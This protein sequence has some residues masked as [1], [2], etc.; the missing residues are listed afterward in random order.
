MADHQALIALSGQYADQGGRAR[1]EDLRALATGYIAARR[2]SILDAAAIAFTFDAIMSKD[3]FDVSEVTPEMAE[4]WSLAYPNVPI[5]SLAGRST[6]ELAGAI[7]GW[8]GKLFEV[9]VVDRLNSGEWVGDLRLESGQTA[10]IAE[11]A[12]QPGW[13]IQIRDEDGAV[14]DAIQLKA[15][16]SIS[17]VH[18]ALAR[19]P[20]TP[21]L[22]THEVADR[23]GDHPM[24]MDSGISN[25]ALTD[26]VNQHVAD[27]SSDTLSDGVIGA[28]PLS[29]IAITEASKVW[30]GKQT[31]DQALESGGERVA[32][33]VVA[34]AV[35]AAVSSVATPLVGLV[36]GFITRLALTDS[37]QPVRPAKD[38]GVAPRFEHLYGSASR[39]RDAVAVIAK[40]YGVPTQR[41]EAR[42]SNPSASNDAKELASFVDQDTRL[43]IIRGAMPLKDW[44]REMICK[45]VLSMSA[46]EIEQHLADLQLIK[47]ENLLDDANPADGMLDAIG[48]ALFSDHLNLGFALDN[49]IG[50]AR[51]HKKS[52]SGSIT[53]EEH[54][55]L[56]AR[57]ALPL[58]TPFEQ[59][60]RTARKGIQE[61]LQRIISRS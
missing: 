30:S 5:E 7:S 28:M 32:K 61:E 34:G 57:D 56:L 8:K 24:V 53:A 59:G 2:T 48:R 44:I 21:I 47:D 19:Y 17:Y 18:E 27:A 39:F 26:S 60:R 20:D 13:D 22:A 50:K 41:P 6:E 40:D 16:E 54:E 10:H 55:E 12:T 4:A 25:D 31:L 51:L 52:L 14:L 35:A 1:I 3:A 29:L 58:E 33:G 11:S 9:E 37:D 46:D 15:T 38:P 45:S 42:G 49:A 23:L 36:A 43:A